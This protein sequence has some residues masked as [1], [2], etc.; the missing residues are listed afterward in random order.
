M[1]NT[2]EAIGSD[3][4]GTVCCRKLE[5]HF[6]MQPLL[7]RTGDIADFPNVKTQTQTQRVR[8]MKR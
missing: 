7:S 3:E 2:P 1:G 5:D 6:F 4:Q 8:Q